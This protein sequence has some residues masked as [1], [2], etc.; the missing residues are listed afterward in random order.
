MLHPELSWSTY[1]P[2]GQTEITDSEGDSV[3]FM[4]RE[5]AEEKYL[6]IRKSG[7]NG[8]VFTVYGEEGGSD[9]VDLSYWASQGELVLDLR[10]NSAEEGVEFW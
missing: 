8:N 4:D 1:N 2:E 9:R 10:V 5:D 6:Q 7:P 3:F